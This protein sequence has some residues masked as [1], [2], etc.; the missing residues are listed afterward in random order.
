MRRLLLRQKK[1]RGTRRSHRE[2]VTVHDGARS[3]RQ[4]LKEVIL[5][6]GDGICLAAGRRLHRLLPAVFFPCQDEA[7]V[8]GQLRRL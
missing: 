3:Q 2:P 4:T 5:R 7:L 6:G 1:N 8:K